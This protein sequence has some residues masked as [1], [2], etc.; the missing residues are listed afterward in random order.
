MSKFKIGLFI[1]LIIV[2]LGA[3][4]LVYMTTR[5][6][7]LK[8]SEQLISSSDG[9]YI[10]SIRKKKGVMAYS[11]DNKELILYNRYFMILGKCRFGEHPLNIENWDDENILITIST[12]YRNEERI[13]YITRWIKKNNRIG[14]FNIKYKL[15]TPEAIIEY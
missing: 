9:K 3:V 11:S 8:Y 12:R 13:N 2:I 14:K 10:L 15:I 7:V 1:I 6:R 5:H 4:I